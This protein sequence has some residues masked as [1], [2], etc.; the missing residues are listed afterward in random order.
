MGK[1]RKI[2]I[3]GSDYLYGV[4]KDFDIGAR[5]EQVTFRAYLDGYNVS[6]F[7]LEFN[8]AE[9]PRIIGVY[10]HLQGTVNAFEPGVARKLIEYALLNG[11]SPKD[12]NASKIFT[13]GEDFLDYIDRNEEG[14]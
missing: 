2:H 12:Q 3:N 7:V 13:N 14:T 6:P 10:L 9:N 5:N 8:G 4:K 11:W 1:L